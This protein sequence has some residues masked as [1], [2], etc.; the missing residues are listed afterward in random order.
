MIKQISIKTKLGWISALENKGKI[1]RIKFCKLKKQ[2]KSIILENFKKKLLQFF[3]K[4]T[5]NIKIP[6]EMFGNKIQKKIWNELKKIK[7]G[8]P[9]TYGKIAK[10]HKI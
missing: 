6:H 3:D 1:F 9:S 8:H 5:P 10:K 4:K 2:K 7:I